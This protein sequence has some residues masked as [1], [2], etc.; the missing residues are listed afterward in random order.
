MINT[1]LKNKLIDLGINFNQIDQ[2][3]NITFLDKGAEGVVYEIDNTN[4]V[5]KMSINKDEFKAYQLLLTIDEDSLNGLFEI[6][7]VVDESDNN[8]YYVFTKLKNLPKN[9]EKVMRDIVV[10]LDEH[11]VENMTLL[12]FMKAEVIRHLNTNNHKD[13]YSF[14]QFLIKAHNLSKKYNFSDI[15]SDNIMIDENKNFKII[16]IQ[17]SE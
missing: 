17:L 7:I 9:L 4:L 15:H 2:M 14:L 5:L 8:F 1:I 6:P 12:P 16:D 13:Y 11:N 3:T 10:F